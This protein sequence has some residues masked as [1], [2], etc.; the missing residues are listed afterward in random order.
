MQGISNIGNFLQNLLQF[1]QN[2]R[3]SFWMDFY[4]RRGICSI[5]NDTLV[6]SDDFFIVSTGS[7]TQVTFAEKPQMKETF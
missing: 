3:S 5:H 2:Y 7:N 1:V 6:N 4:I